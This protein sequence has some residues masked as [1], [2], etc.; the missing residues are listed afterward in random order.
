MC[1]ATK[2]IS[3]TE[4]AYR[5][6]A[7][8]K[9]EHESFSLVINRLTGTHNLL[10]LAGSLS[11]SAAERLEKNIAR[12]RKAQASVQHDRIKRIREAFE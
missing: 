4:A 8:M 10:E 11:E 1:M 5:R 7:S 9:R 12:V 2:N 3:I 6:L